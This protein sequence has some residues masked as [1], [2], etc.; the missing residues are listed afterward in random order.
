MVKVWCE[1][2][3]GFSNINDYDSVFETLKECHEVLDNVNWKQVG[4]DT[5]Q[6]VEEDGLL[7]IEDDGELNEPPKIKK[8]LVKFDFGLR[9][10]FGQQLQV[11]D[12]NELQELKD[13]IGIE[14][15]LGEYEGKHSEVRGPLE[16]SDYTILNV[17]DEFIE[18]FEKHIGSFGIP[19]YNAFKEAVDG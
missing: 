4:Y 15:Y 1:W 8:H 3:M 12:E 10:A 2:D 7:S 17:P 14:I 6:E 18:Q 11:L 9:D 19:I 13:N 5:W 16:E